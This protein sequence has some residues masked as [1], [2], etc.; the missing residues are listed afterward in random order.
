VSLPDPAAATADQLEGQLAGVTDAGELVAVL[1]R[2]LPG[3][4]AGM[5]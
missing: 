2:A 4:V 1:D 3:C 5:D